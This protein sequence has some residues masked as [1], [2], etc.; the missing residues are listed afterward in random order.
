MQNECVSGAPLDVLFHRMA[1]VSA[2]LQDDEG[3]REALQAERQRLIQSV[4]AER[5]GQL[6]FQESPLFTPK[7]RL[8]RRAYAGAA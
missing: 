5:R 7:L 4:M 2:L 8:K 6:P 1:V 3:D